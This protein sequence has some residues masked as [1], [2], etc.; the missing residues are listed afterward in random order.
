[1][2]H[3]YTT[4]QWNPY[5]RRY[6]LWLVLGV[7]AYL[8]CFVGAVLALAPEGSSFSEEVLVLRALGTCAFLLLQLILVVGP[9]ARLSPRWLPLLY[10][11]RHLGVVTFLVGLGHG[12]LSLLYY[13]GFGVTDPLTAVLGNYAGGQTLSSLPFEPLGFGALLILFAMA[14]TSHD[15]WLANLGAGTWKALH[16]LVYPAYVLLVGHVALGALQSERSPLLAGLV[17]AG[18]AGV[19]AL[20]LLAGLVERRRDRAFAVAADDEGWLE[21]DADSLSDE[22]PTVVAAPGGERIAVVRHGDQ[23]SA[24]ASV[25]AHQGGPLGEGRMIDGCLTCPWHGYQYLPAEGRSPPP[26]SETIPTHPVRCRDGRLQ[27]RAEP[28]P[29]GTATPPVSLE[30]RHD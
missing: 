7:L 12:A 26:F 6:D 30:P 19:T 24:V 13:G 5:K 28:L 1:M 11:R 23:V 17:G 15:F 21:V 4:V 10:N 8:A 2:S 16:M 18:V 3:A 25:C 20:H 22:R 27:V 14:A 9:L 29:P